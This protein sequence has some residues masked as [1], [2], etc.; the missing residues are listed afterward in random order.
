[1]KINE[2][3]AVKRGDR[4]RKR[5]PRRQTRLENSQKLTPGQRIRLLVQ[6]LLTNAFDQRLETKVFRRGILISVQRGELGRLEQHIKLNITE[7]MAS[8]SI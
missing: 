8:L 2:P 7:N 4:L 5:I 6:D 3:G 1:M